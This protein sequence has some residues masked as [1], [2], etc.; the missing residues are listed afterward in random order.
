MHRLL[1]LLGLLGALAFVL[2]ATPAF[3]QDVDFGA[4]AIPAVC[5]HRLL[6]SAARGATPAPARGARQLLLLRTG[7]GACARPWLRRKRR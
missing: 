5:C 1:G 3:A 7:S 6:A 4:L 2:L